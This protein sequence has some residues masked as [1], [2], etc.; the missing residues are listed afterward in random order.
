MKMMD[1]R[2]DLFDARDIAA[3]DTHANAGDCVMAGWEGGG[4]QE[5]A[6]KNTLFDRSHNKW[7]RGINLA[8]R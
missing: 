8:R 3:V 2:R 5:V 1:M 6:T 4:D 7:V